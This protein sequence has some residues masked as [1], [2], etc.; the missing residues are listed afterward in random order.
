VLSKFQDES[1]WILTIQTGEC[2]SVV[3]MPV[4]LLLPG[5]TLNETAFP[6]LEMPTVSPDFSRL[7][8]G[9]DGS[10]PELLAQRMDFYSALL[11]ELL[12]ACE[13]WQA[14]TRLVIAH[15]FG[16]MLAL[17]WLTLHGGDDLA[18]IDGLVLISTTAG[19]MYQNL[20]LRL[21]KLGEWDVRVRAGAAMPWWNQPSVTRSVKTLI[22]GSLDSDP[23]DFRSLTIQSDLDLDLV[24]WRN[25]DWRAMR[26]Y[27][28][29]MEG[30][31]VRDSLASVAVPT[32][33]LHGTED[34]LFDT[35]VARGLA[36]GI[37]GAELRLITG[38]GHALPLTHGAE[39]VR[40]M[41]DLLQL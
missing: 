11:D 39:V 17:R 13:D 15:S 38:A 21:F 6:D 40:S 34:A 22:C 3:G 28:L 26:S 14:D 27:R 7:A 19:P 35:D 41:Q 10:S 9:R 4:A 36:A 32:V 1:R 8:V 5:M 12:Q 23:I 37:P 33:V 29:A 20:N 16:G 31:D 24:G 30:F 2:R 25:T 18:R